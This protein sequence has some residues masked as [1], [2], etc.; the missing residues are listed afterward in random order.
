MANPGFRAA[1]L[2]TL[3]MSAVF[4][5]ALL[6]LPQFFQ[7]ILGD[8]PLEAGAGLLPMMAVVRGHLVR[9]RRRSTSGSGPKL[10][11][12]AGAVCLHA[13]RL[14]DLADRARLGLRRARAR[15]GRARHRRRPLLLVDHDRGGDRARPVALEP[16]RR[17][18]STCSRSRAARSGSGSP[19]P[20]SSR[21]ARTGSRRTSPRRGSTRPRSTPC[22][23]R[24]RARR[25]STEI[26]A[27][28][29]R[30]VADRLLELIR[31]AFAAGM[32]WAFRLV[33]ALALVGLVISVLFVGGSLLRP[34][35]P[36]E[37]A[38]PPS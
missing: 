3:L 37:A 35:A 32:Q 34:R 24:S 15:H 21:P 12:I 36:E 38:Q 9:R 13:G 18:S 28:F 14:P 31:E 26:L 2:A 29:S 4:F 33:A 11:V 27:R 30:G 1:C 17:A 20:S 5:A 23:A 22:T 16:R 10:I 19:R 25:R 6:F 8:S 7:K